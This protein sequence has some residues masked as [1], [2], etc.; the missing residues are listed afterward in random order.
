MTSDITDLLEQ[1]P[2]VCYNEALL[3]L[4][5]LNLL[6]DQCSNSLNLPVCGPS[7]HLEFPVVENPL[8]YTGVHNVRVS[9]LCW[10]HCA[11]ADKQKQEVHENSDTRNMNYEVAKSSSLIY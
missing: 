3:Q 10:L 5:Q 9:I 8:C 11:G 6:K 2:E 1:S 7:S 4:F